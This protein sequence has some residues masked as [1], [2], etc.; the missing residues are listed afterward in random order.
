MIVAARDASTNPV[1]LPVLPAAAPSPLAPARAA[2]RAQLIESFA[3]L[4]AGSPAVAARGAVGPAV[5][6]GCPPRNSW[7]AWLGDQVEVLI[8]RISRTEQVDQQLRN[9]QSLRAID[10]WDDDQRL[11]AEE[12]AAQL[13]RNPART[14]AQLATT[15][16]GCEWLARRWSALAAAPAATWTEEQKH[17]A[18]LLSGATLPTPVPPDHVATQIARLE[19]QRER[20]RATDR[21][22]RALVE[23]DLSD[24]TSRPLARLRRYRSSLQRQLLW[25]VTQL[26]GDARGEP[27]A[28]PRPSSPIPVTGAAAGVIVPPATAVMCSPAEPEQPSQTRP[29]SDGDTNPPATSAGNAP[30]GRDGTNPPGP[31]S[32]PRPSSVAASCPPA[33]ATILAERAARVAERKRRVD[34]H[35]ELARLRNAARRHPA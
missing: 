22:L 13:A 15:P 18:W 9:L 4:R 32:G 31:R 33:A 19:E 2:R 7:E 25:F 21:A 29:R 17:D 30:S 24:A 35:R 3:A 28:D 14:V 26:R 20:T 8:G 6:G 11:A 16:A 34:P 10:S 5:V 23:A 27:A 12:A 1:D